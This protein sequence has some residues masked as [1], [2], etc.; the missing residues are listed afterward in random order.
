MEV[1]VQRPNMARVSKAYLIGTRSRKNSDWIGSV[2]KIPI[3][4]RPY[5]R[6]S[7]FSLRLTDRILLL[8]GSEGAETR[9]RC[10]P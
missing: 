1:D 6:S 5:T 7:K 2:S 3:Q 8:G 4:K 10:L 9:K